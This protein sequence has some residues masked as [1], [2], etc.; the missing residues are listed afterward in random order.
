[1]LRGHRSAVTTIISKSGWFAGQNPCQ[2]VN[3]AMQQADWIVGK[4]RCRQVNETMQL[5]AKNYPNYLININFYVII[6][7]RSAV[8]P[9]TLYFIQGT[10]HII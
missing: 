10:E 7:E 2:K 8:L 6:R 1:M 4:P 5:K 3:A 9:M